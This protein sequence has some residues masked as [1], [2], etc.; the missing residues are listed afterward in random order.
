MLNLVAF[1]I[2]KPY[3][4]HQGSRNLSVNSQQINSSILR[5]EFGGVMVSFNSQHNLQ[6]RR[7]S[8]SEKEVVNIRLACGN[9]C[10]AVCGS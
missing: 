5:L 9:V 7:K 4:Y 10:G 2:E 1:T 8:L 6:S 3:I